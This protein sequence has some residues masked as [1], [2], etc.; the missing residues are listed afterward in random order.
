MSLFTERKQITIKRNGERK[1]QL[2]IRQLNLRFIYEWIL[3][4]LYN[5]ILC[6]DLL[7]IFSQLFHAWSQ[8]QQSKD[9][10]IHFSLSFPPLRHFHLQK[11]LILNLS[12]YRKN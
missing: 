5:D 2:M 4:Y 6:V 12:P 10:S 3:T 8:A 9:I 1:C 11:S 7:A